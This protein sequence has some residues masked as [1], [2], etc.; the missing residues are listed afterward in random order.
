MIEA[1]VIEAVGVVVPAHNEEALVTECLRSVRAALRPVDGR[2]RVAVSVV[3]DRCADQTP[4]RVAE[5]LAGWSGA[6]A[7]RVRHR[8][9]G[10]GVGYVRDLGVRDL[11]RRLCPVPPER[12]WLLSTDSDTTVPR[13]WA[14]EQLR[15][16]R[17]G[18][19]GVAGLAELHGDPQLS[20]EALERYRAILADGM[21]GDTHQHVYAANLGLRADIYR[22]SGGFPPDGHGEEHRL[23]RAMADSG[24]RLHRPTEPR[25]RT[26]ARLHGRAEGGLA[27]LLRGI[28]GASAP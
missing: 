3:L 6:R 22:R 15:H 27:E 5:E 17:A 10:T 1:A 11:L 16:A 14:S 4:F 7:L 9:A 8:P 18:A 26:S 12:I 25:V 28:A 13:S 21:S 19:H 20:A 23:W 24:C 2:C